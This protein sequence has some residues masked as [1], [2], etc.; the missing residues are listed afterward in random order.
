[1]WRVTPSQSAFFSGS[2]IPVPLFVPHFVHSNWNDDF[3]V[4][5][6]EILKPRAPQSATALSK[7]KLV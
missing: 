7:A 6:S 1:M 4:S 3:Q 2:L 5:E